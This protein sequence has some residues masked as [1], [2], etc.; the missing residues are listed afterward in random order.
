[1]VIDGNS[2]VSLQSIKLKLVFQ[3]GLITQS[4]IEEFGKK[5]R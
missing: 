1:M 3:N 2:K 5:V 4:V